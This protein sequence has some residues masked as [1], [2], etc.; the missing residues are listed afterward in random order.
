MPGSRPGMTAL[1]DFAC[2]CGGL[3]DGSCRSASSV[4]LPIW[5]SRCNR[6]LKK[7]RTSRSFKAN[8]RLESYKCPHCAAVTPSDLRCQLF[9]LLL[10]LQLCESLLLKTLPSQS[11]ALQHSCF[12]LRVSQSLAY[13]RVGLR[14]EHNATTTA[15]RV[16]VLNICNSFYVG[17]FIPHRTS[18]S[19]T[20]KERRNS[21]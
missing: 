5:A 6:N 13:T 17:S 11:F 7:R 8:R 21:D 14:N 20:R 9:P 1:S 15:P 12:V 18:R 4:R 19:S 2:F 10:S 16:L 3:R